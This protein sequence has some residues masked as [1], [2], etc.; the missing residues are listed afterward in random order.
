MRGNARW[1]QSHCGQWRCCNNGRVVQ[2]CTLQILCGC[3][4]CGMIRR[5]QRKISHIS[6]EAWVRGAA[7][8]LA[9]DGWTHGA[10]K[11]LAAAI[12][13]GPRVSVEV[14]ARGAVKALAAAISAGKRISAEVCARVAVKALAT[15]IS[16]GTHISVKVWV[17][18]SKGIIRRNQRRNTRIPPY[19]HAGALHCQSREGRSS[20]IAARIFSSAR[21]SMRDTYE[22][23]MPSAWATSC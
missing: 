22:R 3:Y 4:C 16:A 17:W 13:A 23:D 19:G 11:A 20:S 9:A 12:S 5:N 10:V 21:F 8:A 15:A 14:C 7:N 2:R 1:D 18:C 6:T